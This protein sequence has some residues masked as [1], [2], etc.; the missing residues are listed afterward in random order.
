MNI[1]PV[2]PS[3]LFMVDFAGQEGMGND[4]HGIVCS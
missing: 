4:N 3:G 1:L 2:T